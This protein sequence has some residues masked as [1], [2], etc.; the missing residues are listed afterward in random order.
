MEQRGS[1]PPAHRRRDDDVVGVGTRHVDPSSELCASWTGDHDCGRSAAPVL[2]E[3]LVELWRFIAAGLD[4][5]PA[6]S[7]TPPRHHQVRAP[8]EGQ[9]HS[10]PTSGHETRGN[11]MFT[12]TSLWAVPFEDRDLQARRRRALLHAARGRSRLVRP[13]NPGHTH[14]PAPSA[15]PLT[16]ATAHRDSVTPGPSPSTGRH[17]ETSVAICRQGRRGSSA[18]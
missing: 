13:A 6:I 2:G 18:V 4:V 1:R 10:W 12:T 7:T 9:S 14:A 17:L 15:H 3:R 11:L 5:V 16:G 8:T